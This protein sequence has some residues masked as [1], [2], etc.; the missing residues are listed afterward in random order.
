MNSGKI[1]ESNMNHLKKFSSILL[2]FLL[3]FSST[4]TALAYEDEYISVALGANG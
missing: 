4:L 2:L 3:S 1:K